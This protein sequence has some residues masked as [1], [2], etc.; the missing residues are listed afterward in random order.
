[1]TPSRSHLSVAGALL[2]L[3]TLA[4]GSFAPPASCGDNIG[5]T[6]DEAAFAQYFISMQL[7]DEATGVAGP[8]DSES[9]ATFGPDETIAISYSTVGEGSV[10]ACVQERAGGGGIPLDETFS[11]VHGEGSFSLGSFPDGTYVVRAILAD[12]LVR[13]LT[14]TVR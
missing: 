2:L 13:N 8:P 12:T 6:A 10:R 1:M 7:V 5:G 3:T 9:Q 14:F 4:C 11:F